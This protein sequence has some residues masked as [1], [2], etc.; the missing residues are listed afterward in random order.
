MNHI[1]RRMPPVGK[2]DDCGTRKFM[3]LKDG[4]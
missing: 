3:A 2:I 1:L 4:D